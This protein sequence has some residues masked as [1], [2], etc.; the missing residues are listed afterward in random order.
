MKPTALDTMHHID[1]GID[2]TVKMSIDQNSIAHLMQILTDLYSDPILAVVREYATNALDSHIEAGNKDPIEITLPSSLKPEFQVRDKGVGLNV[3]DLRDIYSMYGRSTKRNSD[4]VT[5]M[6]GLGC[7]SGLTYALSFTVTGVKDGLKTVAI[8][9]KDEDGVGAVKIMDTASTDEE[10]GVTVSIPVKPHDIQ[11]FC[12]TAQDLFRYWKPGTVKV[13]GEEPE[14]P[15][16]GMLWL[17]EDVAV[18]SKTGYNDNRIVMGGVPYPFNPTVHGVSIVAWVPMGSVNFTPSREALHFTARTDKTIEEICEFVEQRMPI[19]IG[20]A[21]KQASTPYEKLALSLEWWTHAKDLLKDHWSREGKIQLPSDKPSW[22]LHLNSYRTRAH[23]YE[24]VRLASLTR[25]GP[26]ITEYPNK[27]VPGGARIRC[28]ELFGHQQIMFLPDGSD[29][30]YLEGRDE[31]YTW[32]HVLDN[33]EKPT[34]NRGPASQTQY[35]VYNNGTC[36]ST[37]QLKNVKNIVYVEGRASSYTFADYPEV[38]GVGLQNRQ[39]ARF[40]R[41][42][43]KAIPFH[44]YRKKLIARLEK[45]LTDQDKMFWGAD[46]STYGI[47]KDQEKK[48]LDPDLKAIAEIMNGKQSVALARYIKIAG[49]SA[50]DAHPIHETMLERYPLLGRIEESGYHNGTYSH[51]ATPDMVEDFLFYINNKFQTMEDK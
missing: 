39:V 44:E 49:G 32:Q 46:T 36:T 45:K 10:N 4:A 1:H 29:L 20:Q 21:L 6:L 5:G 34:M 8:V 7:K 41:L 43:P 19:V 18:F 9:T 16:E 2:E 38:Y 23:K 11:R 14:F 22:D 17:D 3:G 31:V 42:H 47:L 30:T 15:T 24:E 33:T 26:I 28:K 35:E 51:K 40:L 13:D 48:I 50:F 37:P 12:N 25:N 27:T